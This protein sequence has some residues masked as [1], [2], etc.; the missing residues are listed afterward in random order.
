[1]AADQTLLLDTLEGLS[2]HAAQGQPAASAKDAAKNSPVAL[3]PA[4]AEKATE[5]PPANPQVV[6]LDKFRKK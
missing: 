1:M 6:S 2:D 3:P 5:T 4:E